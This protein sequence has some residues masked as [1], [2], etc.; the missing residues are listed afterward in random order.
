M[1]KTE[2]VLARQGQIVE[3]DIAATHAYQVLLA[4]S[5][6][7]GDPGCWSA[8]G[9][10]KG[11]LEALVAHQE[12]LLSADPA[13]L[14]AWA[15]GERSDF[16]P[17]RDLE[18]ILAARLE[19]ARSLPVNLFTDYLLENTAAAKLEARAVASLY[20]TALEVERDGALLE[21]EFRLYIA[22]GLPV[23]VGQ[24]G[25]PGGDGI[26]SKSASPSRRRPAR[27]PSIPT[28]PPGRSPA[29][30]YGTGARRTFASATPRYL[31]PK[32]SPSRT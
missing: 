31:P 17:A 2:E 11:E 10:S 29:G 1:A 6:G 20:Q 23:Y 21:D 24:L 3:A 19:S 9:L 5:S 25:L 22:L 12:S 8:E 28:R 13:A 32:S 16:D 30:R 27:R 4:L 26:S 18:P 15:E 14:A 7:E